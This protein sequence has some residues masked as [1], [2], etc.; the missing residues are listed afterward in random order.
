MSLIF[1]VV[2]VVAPGSKTYDAYIYCKLPETLVGELV[3]PF[4]HEKESKSKEDET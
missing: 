1:V 2:G 4:F 3:L